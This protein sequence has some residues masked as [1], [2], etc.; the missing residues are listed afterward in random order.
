MGRRAN[1][2][3]PTVQF[4]LSFAFYRIFRWGDFAVPFVLSILGY[5]IFAP[6]DKKQLHQP[7]EAP[8]RVRLAKLLVTVGVL[9]ML[10]GFIGGIVCL[11][12]LVVNH[13]ILT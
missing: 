6:V 13:M 4:A 3:G 1:L 8:Q 11:N 2:K 7:S 5:L 10:G 12:L 9:L